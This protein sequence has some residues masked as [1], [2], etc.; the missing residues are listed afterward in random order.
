MP[1]KMH[2]PALA[3]SHEQGQWISQPMA[4]CPFRSPCIV[5]LLQVVRCVQELPYSVADVEVLEDAE[6]LEAASQPAMAAVMQV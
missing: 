2:S 6:L 4:V 1:Q 5:L 3:L